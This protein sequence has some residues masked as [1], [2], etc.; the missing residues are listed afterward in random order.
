MP[1]I[2]KDI[3]AAN[4]L[5]RFLSL[6]GFLPSLAFR[7]QSLPV[8]PTKCGLSAASPG[9]SERHLRRQPRPRHVPAAALGCCWLG[10]PA[11]PLRY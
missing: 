9:P 8:K 1:R 2:P 5:C 7:L 10:A 6:N 4:A 11:L 3:S